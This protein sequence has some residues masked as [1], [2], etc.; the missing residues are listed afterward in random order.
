VDLVATENLVDV[1]TN[2][3]ASATPQMTM[4][5]T[6]LTHPN[7]VSEIVIAIDCRIHPTRV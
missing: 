7:N 2:V 3:D 1:I 6:V 5:D 4:A